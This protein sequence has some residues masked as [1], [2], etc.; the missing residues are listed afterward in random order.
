[1]RRFSLLCTRS[2][3]EVASTHRMLLT[4]LR[5]WSGGREKAV[6]MDLSSVR[7]GQ[8]RLPRR[9]RDAKMSAATS[10]AIGGH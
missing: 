10:S 7:R 9:T 3:E 4:T 6:V 2:P 8:C 5:G 1:M